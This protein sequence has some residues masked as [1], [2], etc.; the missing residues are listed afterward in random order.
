MAIDKSLYQAPTGLMPPDMD[1]LSEEFEMEENISYTPTEDGG[2]EIVIG[3]EEEESPLDNIAFGANLAEYL[4]EDDLSHLSSELMELVDADIQSRKEWVDTYVEGMEVLGIKYEEKT[5]PW[6]GACGAFS[7]LLLESVM[8]FQAETMA[9][10]F[11]A[12]GPVRTKILGE[13]TPE[14]TAAAERVKQDMNYELTDV[15]VEYRSEHER[16]L[17]SLGLGGSAFKK[18]YFDPNLG[19]QTSVF[20]P[21][22]DV[23]VPFSTSVI[24]H[25]ERVTHTM[26][27]TKNELLKSQESGFYRDIDLGEPLAYS[28]DVEKKKADL[29]GYTLNEDDRH[30]LFEIHVE[31]VIEGVND[32]N[33]LD[34]DR[35]IGCPYVVTIDQGTTKVIGI[36]RNWEKGDPLKKKRQYFVHYG[37]LPGIGFYNLGLIHILGGHARTVTSL[38]R[39]LVDAGTLANLQGGF[40]AKG[41]RTDGNNEPIGA[42]E[43]KDIDV[44]SGTLRDN[45]MPLPY[46]E[47]SA[48]LVTLMDRL[49]EEGRRIG[50]TGDLNVADMSANAPV[51]TTLALLERT[52]KNMSA[53]SARVHYA[54]K[55]EFKL[56]K[57]LIAKHAP[58]EYGYVP[59][60]GEP[61]ARKSDYEMVDIIPVSDPNNS[62]MAQRVVQH[63]AVHQLSTSAPQIYNLPAF[64]RQMIETLGVKNA[65]KIVP[66]DADQEPL[67]PISENMNV[68]M[69]KPIKVF[70]Q[71]D[72][73][74]HL[75][76][77]TA[78]EQD[79]M[80][81][82]SLGQNP[83]AQ[84]MMAA[85][86]AHNAEHMAYLYRKQMEEK[87]GTPLPLPGKS[88]PSM[89]EVELS[90]MMGAAGQQLSQLHK[91]Q[92]AQKQ[93]EEQAKDP[94][95]QLKK[96]E[97]DLKAAEVQRKTQKDADDKEIAQQKL[98]LE[99]S[100]VASTSQERDKDRQ[101]QAGESQKKLQGEVQKELLKNALQPPTPP[102]NEGR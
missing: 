37:Y 102:K 38:I 98:G 21:A 7:S 15:M 39:Q 35:E 81:M 85:L 29:G 58:E 5:I 24:E 99:A 92:A 72:H 83:M 18:V 41:T 67:D 11:P 88:L 40:K 20:A 47:P 23:I 54:Q 13:E 9:E 53:V 79:P 95:F 78:F 45:I 55:Q 75:S 66:V 89:I 8:R 80:I 87:L 86:K 4:E 56:L 97:A 25:A 3:E 46:K 82:Q 68:L 77:H 48:T 61:R 90:R 70:M 91:Q 22:E 84:Q 16:M 93:G 43:W 30:T 19:R 60:R 31:M 101:L 63:Q 73:E 74:A 26:R 50:A 2:I 51:G 71:Q 42:G 12:A 34:E 69:S 6:M 1:M 64:H 32:G 17:F 27:R 44:A 65:E 57:G 52:L 62:T 96:Q 10:T 33:K 100:K 28:T 36:R 14:N 94:V 59:E 76:A 49:V